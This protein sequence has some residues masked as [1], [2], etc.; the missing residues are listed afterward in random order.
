M[1]IKDMQMEDIEV[2]SAELVEAMTA[3]DADIEQIQ[4][5]VTE[6]EERKAQI[7]QE[8]EA[9]KAQLEEVIETSEEIK[10]P[11]IE[12]EERTMENVMNSPEYIRAYAKYLHTEDDR[13]LR[14]L[15]TENGSGTVAVPEFV[16][17]EVKTAWEEEGIMSRVRKA[18]LKGNLKVGFEISATGATVHT[19]G[20]SVNEQ[21]LTLGIIELKPEAIKKWISISDEALDL[22]NAEAYIRHIYRELAHHIAKKAADELIAKIKAC[23]TQSTTTCVGVP[24]IASTQITVGLVAQALGQLSGEAA[25]PVVMMNKATWSAFKAAQYAAQYPVDPF[26]GLP[27][28]F[29]DSIASFATATTGVPYMIVGDLGYGALANF[30]NGEEIQIKRD[31][32]TLATSDLVRFIGREYV[33]L[34]IVAPNAFVKVTK[35]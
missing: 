22:D 1:E 8:A 29:N 5:E 15:L 6:L 13:E 11:I 10:E 4:A 7:I 34:G 28:V 17:D 9:R 12:E 32:F 24:A 20:Q 25:N 2:R 16:Y 27:V 23:G 26:E 33:G 31:D 35:N 18:Y 21:T 30:P 14:A 19:E 3:E